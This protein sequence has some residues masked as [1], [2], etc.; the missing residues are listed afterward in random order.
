M[1]RRS[2][3]SFSTL[4][5]ATLAALAVG[6]STPAPTLA[7]EPPRSGKT[8]RVAPEAQKAIDMLKSPFC[9]GEMLAVCP[10]EGGAMLRD[11]IQRMAERG[12]KAD[13]IISIVLGEYGPDLRAQPLASGTGLWAWVLPPAVLLLGFGVVGVVLANRR[14]TMEGVPVMVPED[15]DPD[16]EAR[17]KAAMKEMDEAEEPDF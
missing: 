14:R 3:A 12:L 17:L 2:R 5:L 8:L 15:V 6:A 9:P 4:L 11:S 16:T 7:Q 10:S 13:S 1:T